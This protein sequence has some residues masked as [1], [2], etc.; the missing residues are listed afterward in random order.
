MCGRYALY[1]PASR[2]QDDFEATIEGFE[3]K[4]R[5]NAAPM[6]WLPVI[7][8]R[9]DGERVIYALRWGLLPGWANDEAVAT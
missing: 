5:Y 8:Q 3:F 4:P 1:G 9:S 7:R 6:Q 2:L